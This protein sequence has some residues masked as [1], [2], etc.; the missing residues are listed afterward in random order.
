MDR[1]PNPAPIM[2]MR[3]NL[4]T[5]DQKAF[6]TILK[7]PNRSKAYKSDF[8]KK[9]HLPLPST[10]LGCASILHL[11]YDFLNPAPTLFLLRYFQVTHKVYQPSTQ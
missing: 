7:R 2:R 1:L 10:G 5:A 6:D 9:T 8:R 11:I 4:S 3:D